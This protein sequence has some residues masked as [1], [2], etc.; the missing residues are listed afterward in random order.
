MAGKIFNH[1]IDS[2]HAGMRQRNIYTRL[3]DAGR[4]CGID[5]CASKKDGKAYAPPWL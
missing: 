1:K 5:T 4:C 2:I 3:Q